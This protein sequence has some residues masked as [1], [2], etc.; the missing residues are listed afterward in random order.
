MSLVRTQLL[1][2]ITKAVTTVL[3]IIQS[4]IVVRLLSPAEFGLVG[5][6]MSIGG[7][8][9]VSQHLGIVDGAIRE[10]AV[11]K[12]KREIAKVFWVSHFTRQAV[13]I[14]LSLGLFF[15]AP[16]IAEGIY[17]RPEITH[18]IQLFASVL[19][20]QGL[21]DVL[22][23]TLTGMK[24]FVTLY[25]VQIITAAV[26][27]GAFGYLTWRYG[28]TGF[29]WAVLATTSLMIILFIVL[30]RKYLPGELALPTWAETKQ[31]GRQLMKIGF[32]MYVARI[33]FVA[34]QRLP[35]LILGGVLGAH[36]LGYI[37]V[38]LTFGARMT[39]IAMALS[40]VNLA[41]MSTLYANRREE[42]AHVVTRNLHRV[43]LVMAAGTA[44]L[45]FFTPEI[46]TYIVGAEYEPARHLIYI[47][48]LAF[49][50]Y[51]LV[52]IGTSSIFVPANNPKARTILYGVMF[53]ISAVII[54]WLWSTRPD[55]LLACF[56][57]LSGVIVAYLGMLWQARHYGVRLLTGELALVVLALVAITAWLF[58]DPLLVTRLVVFAAF[59]S[60]LA[61]IMIHSNL[62][63]KNLFSRAK[64]VPHDAALSAPS[65]ICFA[66][67][68][69]EQPSWT[70][71]QHM[72]SRISGRYP[73][74]YV[75]PRVWI[76]RFLTKH[77][78]R[79]GEIAR[80]FKRLCWYE[81]V[82]DNLYLKA[83]WNL[84]PGSREI[85]FISS[86]NH[87]LN[88]W[89]VLLSAKL[90]GFRQA[91]SVVWIYDTEAAEYLK[92]FTDATIIYD[93]VDDHAAQAGADRNPA[94]VEAEEQAIMRRANVVTVTS[95][96]LYELKR[97][98]NPNVH[99]VLNAGDVELFSQRLST[100][101]SQLA[102]L[103]RP[104]FGTVGALDAYKIDFPLLRHVAT[105]RP[106]WQFVFIGEPLI[107]SH[108]QDLLAL[109]ELRNVHFLGSIDRTQVPQYVQAFDV[110]LIP[111]RLSRYN[112]A[113]FPLKFWEFMATAKPLIVAGLPE[114]KKYQHLIAYVNSAG[115]FIAAAKRLLEN[116]KAQSEE[117]QQLAA[118]H[119]WTKR[120]D[121]VLELLS[122]T[123]KKSR[124]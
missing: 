82:N 81:K 9:G 89:C 8:I 108:H 118:Q 79:P 92:D 27:I 31:Y 14:P 37:N 95:E 123:L 103:P 113:S 56:A 34:W 12:N 101:V 46:L 50:L 16:W 22:G 23:A 65:I 48:T 124:L 120:A 5:L 58:I 41:W 77:W 1:S 62:L 52:D 18:Y 74:L 84:I 54:A 29:F 110:C 15:L 69:Y 121:A 86:L 96:R 51:S 42:F 47:M 64:A 55:P 21:Q 68:A 112:E 75:E 20:L 97:G 119:S 28:I 17:S 11:L 99:L 80:F 115:E 63:P 19:I 71:R 53:A 61:W 66:G 10:I 98:S 114:L 67:A 117:R 39:I 7:V 106:D 26:N 6:V 111:Y 76:F 93:C 49:F 59:I 90:L 60:Y 36:E 3:G 107:D 109:K 33:F 70:N 85:R 38:S 43:M 87:Y 94:R 24:K 88:R 73:V 35:L 57:I 40:E 102:A 72:M 116:P 30:V 4:L 44:I 122:A 100:N 104:I 13:T 78:S 83:Q 105:R 45:L 32:F 25:L 91:P 2:L